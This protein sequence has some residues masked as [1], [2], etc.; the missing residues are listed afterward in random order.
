MNRRQAFKCAAGGVFTAWASRSLQGQQS[1]TDKLSV[2]DGGGANVV[3]F[4]FADGFVLV[5]GGAAK[6][7]DK[8]MAALGS[9]AKVK[10]LFNTHHHL[11]QTGNNEMFSAA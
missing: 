1:L 3:A 11:D 4:S 9:N 7:G 5:D 6:S 2:I 10:T 8:V